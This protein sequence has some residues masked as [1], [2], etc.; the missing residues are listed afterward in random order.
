MFEVF[1]LDRY[2]TNDNFKI[3]NQLE[4]KTLEHNQQNHDCKQHH[5]FVFLQDKAAM[6]ARSDAPGWPWPRQERWIM[7]CE[8]D[9]LNESLQSHLMYF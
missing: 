5:V 9:F 2:S 8:E 7:L 6:L 4:P 3:T 1:F